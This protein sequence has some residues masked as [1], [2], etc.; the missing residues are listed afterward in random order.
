MKVIPTVVSAPEHIWVPALTT[1]W[2]PHTPDPRMSSNSGHRALWTPPLIKP[3]LW[4]S[5]WSQKESQFH[6]LLPG[7]ALAL[8]EHKSPLCHTPSS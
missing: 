4:P 2:P 5:H 1:D 3:L 6:S 8:M 7:V